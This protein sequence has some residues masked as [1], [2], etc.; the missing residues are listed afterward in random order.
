MANEEHLRM[1]KQ[2]GKVWNKWREEDADKRPDL[3]GAYLR[4]ANLGGALLCGADL[5][6][7]NLSGANLTGADLRWANL[8]GPETQAA[9][10]TTTEMRMKKCV[11]DFMAGPSFVREYIDARPTSRMARP[12][13]SR[14][15]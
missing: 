6:G 1:I 5:G 15:G 12:A 10:A 4:G 13:R 2:G 14:G 11:W 8:T 7:T 3:A 9:K